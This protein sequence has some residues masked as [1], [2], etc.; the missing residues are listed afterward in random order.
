[1]QALGVKPKTSHS[2]TQQLDEHERKQLLRR[3]EAAAAGGSGDQDDG[4]GGGKGL[5]YRTVRPARHLGLQ[6]CLVN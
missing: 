1:M 2:Q 6:R 4:D 5:G 3:N